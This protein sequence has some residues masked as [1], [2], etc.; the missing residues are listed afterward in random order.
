M[1]RLAPIYNRA[2]TFNPFLIAE[3]EG[4]EYKYVDA[5]SEFEGQTSNVIGKPLIVLNSN[6]IDSPR[7]FVVMA[8]EICHVLLHNGLISYYTLGSLQQSKMEYEAN[9]F[10]SILLINFFVEYT[11]DMP[12]SFQAMQN[13][14][15]LED[16]YE[17]FY[18]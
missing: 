16:E 8:H 18:F 15:M 10:T 14:F 1:N 7:R 17:K 2:K 5:S 6:L 9:K 13:E 12:E 11:G 4:I 3:S